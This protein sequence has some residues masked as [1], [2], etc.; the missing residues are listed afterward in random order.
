MKHITYSSL[1]LAT[2]SKKSLLEV[3]GNL[4]PVF[5]ETLKYWILTSCASLAFLGHP[6]SDGVSKKIPYWIRYFITSNSLAPRD[7]LGYSIDSNNYSV[8]GYHPL[9]RKDSVTNTNAFAVYEK[10]GL[11]FAWDL[12]L[13][14]SVDF[15]LCFPWL[16]F[17]QCLTS[18][19]SIDHLRYFS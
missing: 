7:E 9:I 15:Y 10:E 6:S 5:P 8:R 11:P 12:S 1:R 19:F 2:F 13:E 17:I 3:I 16:Y 14:N 18:F 4:E